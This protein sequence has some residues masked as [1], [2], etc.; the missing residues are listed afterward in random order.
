MSSRGD[1]TL[2]G[3]LQIAD[4]VDVQSVENAAKVR[5]D[6][7]KWPSAN[8]ALTMVNAYTG[9]SV[10]VAAGTASISTATKDGWYDVAFVDAINTNIFC[11]AMPG[12][13]KTARSARAI[14]PSVW[15]MTRSGGLTSR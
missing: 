4:I 12:I 14:R 7:G 11:A 3:Q 1:T 2:A 9:E 10:T 8:G 6:F 15:N 5:F 13:W